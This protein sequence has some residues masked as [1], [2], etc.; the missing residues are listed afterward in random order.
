MEQKNNDS[1]TEEI[2]RDIYRLIRERTAKAFRMF[3]LIPCE[4]TIYG[5]IDQ[6]QYGYMFN[7]QCFISACLDS[8]KDDFV[9]KTVY[10]EE[11]SG[12][13]YIMYTSEDEVKKSNDPFLIL[14]YRSAIRKAASDSNIV[15]FFIN[16]PSDPAAPHLFMSRRNIEMTV[17][18]GEEQIGCFAQDLREALEKYPDDYFLNGKKPETD[19][20]E[21]G[22]QNT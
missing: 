16:P 4:K 21:T 18:N 14:T 12:Y 10:V 8:E 20:T 15:G 17:T 1:N 22:K 6:I 3:N 11:D 9:M 13:A 5:V 19:P 2:T 7:A